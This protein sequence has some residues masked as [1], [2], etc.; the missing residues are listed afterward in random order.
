V[1]LKQII[2]WLIAAVLLV[3]VS[4]ALINRFPYRSTEPLSRAFW[5]T[6]GTP[7]TPAGE[8]SSYSLINA[9]VLDQHDGFT[10]VVGDEAGRLRGGG[11]DAILIEGESRMIAVANL[12]PDQAGTMSR[13]QRAIAIAGIDPTVVSIR[14][15]DSAGNHLEQPYVDPATG[16]RFVVVAAA[17]PIELRGIQLLDAVGRV[18]TTRS[19][20]N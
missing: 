15:F 10:I 5:S 14:V 4:V 17:S 9:V 7:V 3:A 11:R 8:L 2:R 6:T 19:A 13:P 16:M 1:R 12:G 18:V 20:G